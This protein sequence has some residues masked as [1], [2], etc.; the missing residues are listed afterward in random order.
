[1]TT[2]I[3]VDRHAHLSIQTERPG[4]AVIEF[5][6]KG[7]TPPRRTAPYRLKPGE[8]RSIYAWPGVTLIVED[9]I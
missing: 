1:M 4:Q 7:R 5:P 8:P 3:T 6:A 9:L 2:R